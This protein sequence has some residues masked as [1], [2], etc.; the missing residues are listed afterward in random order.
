MKETDLMAPENVC[1]KVPLWMA[2]LICIQS[3]EAPSVHGY[4]QTTFFMQLFVLMQVQWVI[5]SFSKKIM[6]DHAELGWWRITFVRR[7]LYAWVGQHV[8][9]LERN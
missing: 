9:R 1:G 5:P 3:Q 2:A 6:L 4:I 8:L 7:I